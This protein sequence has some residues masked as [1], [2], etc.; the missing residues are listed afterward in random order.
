MVYIRQ[1]AGNK[2]PKKSRLSYL[3]D[4]VVKTAESIHLEPK[5]L[6]HS[7][8][9]IVPTIRS[10]GQCSISGLKFRESVKINSIRM[11]EHISYII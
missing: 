4:T 6:Q 3:Y 2:Q 10:M 1:E 11:P 7:N 8:I 5:S 9:I